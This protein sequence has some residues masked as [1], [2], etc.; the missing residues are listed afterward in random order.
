MNGPKISLYGFLNAV[1]TVVYI[2]L[3]SLLLYNGNRIFGN[4]RSPLNIVA[5]LCL[6]VLSAAVIST[7][8]FGRPA[9]WY[10]N[11]AK[12]EAIKLFFYSIIW[13]LVFT[14]IFLLLVA[15]VLKGNI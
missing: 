2:A 10:F 7:L 12:K 6:F 13:L 15:T 14:V 4:I 5:L 3:I 11:G 8:L 1:A 9:L